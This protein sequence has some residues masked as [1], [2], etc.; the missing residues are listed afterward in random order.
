M[1][2]SA[3]DNCKAFFDTYKN[4]FMDNANVRVLEI[5]SQDVNGSLREHCPKNYEYIG[6]DFVDVKGVDV[7]ITDPYSFPFDDEYFDIILSSSCFEHSEMF[8][9]T[10]L[11]ILRVLKPKGLFYLNVPSSGPFHRY[12]VDCWR[13]YP[14]AGGALI[15]WAKRN[16]INAS[17]LESYTQTET[18]KDYISVFLKDEKYLSYFSK[19]ILHTKA[20]FTNGIIDQGPDFLNFKEFVPL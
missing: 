4:F 16:G 20:D 18:W 7:V 19:R 17:L 10:Y 11:D 8:W 14:D 15:T 1:H 13:F 12:P 3:M 6:V 2:P 5:G 9:L